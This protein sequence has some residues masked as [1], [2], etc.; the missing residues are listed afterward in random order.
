M[1]FLQIAILLREARR[2]QGEDLLH[3]AVFGLVVEV[4]VKFPEA[5]H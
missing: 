1:K 5:F 3:R 4:W 2:A